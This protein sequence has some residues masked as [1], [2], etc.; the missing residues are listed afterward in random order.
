MT[1]QPHL[2]ILGATLLLGPACLVGTEQASASDTSTTTSGSDLGTSE[3]DDT[4]GSSEAS[5][6]TPPDSPDSSTDTSTDSSTDSST[7]TSTNETTEGATDTPLVSIPMIQ[8]GGVALGTMV[9]VAYAVV[10]AIADDGVFVQDEGG[11]ELSGVFVRHAA[12]AELVL[13]DRVAI[14]GSVAEVAARTELDAT[15]GAILWLAAGEPPSP[16]L[17]PPD[18]LGDEAWESVLVEVSGHWVVS[19]KLGSAF[20]MQEGDAT[21]TVNALL[22]DFGADP[23]FEHLR[24]GATFTGARGIVD[25]RLD[26]YALAPRTAGDLEG[27]IGVK[28]LEHLVAGDLVI[29]ELMYNPNCQLGDPYETACEWIEIYNA[30]D[31]YVD[32]HGVR[33]D[34]GELDIGVSGQVLEH[35]LISPGSYTWLGNDAMGWAYPQ[36]PDLFLDG[37]PRFNNT[38]TDGATL[39]GVDDVILDSIAPYTASDDANGISLQLAGWLVP[40]AEANNMPGSWCYAPTAMGESGDLGS[41]G[42]PNPSDCNPGLL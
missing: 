22:Y 4:G 2:T 23:A 15:Q 39:L 36:N 8:S 31:C 26:A 3:S 35:H 10:S 42:E 12:M 34:D 19:E 9:E 6:E 32:V 27:F 18:A 20:A 40:S 21:I 25:G 5:T 13:G 38:G 16:T 11:G 30:S 29:T 14:F 24:S 17:V 1:I 37:N 41:P 28:L 33:V 7:E